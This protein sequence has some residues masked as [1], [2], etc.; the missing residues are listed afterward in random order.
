M[1]KILGYLLLCAGLF[2]I[3]FACVGMYKTFILK[4][5][6]AQVVKMSNVTAQTAQAQIQIP[7]DG[8][9]QL[10]NTALFA[11]LMVFLAMVFLATAGGKVASAGINLLKVERIY[12]ALSELDLNKK[13]DLETLKK[14]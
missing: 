2:F 7:M 14:V 12:D 3:F 8:V 9:N 11:I 13:E 5:P 4:A 10:A 1:H 6:V